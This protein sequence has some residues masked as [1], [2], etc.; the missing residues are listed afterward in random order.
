[1]AP[2]TDP[3]P[4]VPGVLRADQLRATVA[5]IAAEQ[6]GDGALPWSRGG[7]LDAWDAV[8]AAMA[9]DVGASTPAR[10]RHD[11]LAAHQ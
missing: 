3:L 11:W 2:V 9:L 5:A 6:A 8:E 1:M 4:E 7:Q 10:G